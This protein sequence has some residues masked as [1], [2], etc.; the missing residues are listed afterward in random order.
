MQGYGLFSFLG[1]FFFGGGLFLSEQVNLTLK[2]MAFQII[3][4]LYCVQLKYI[5]FFSI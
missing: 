3:W 4:N 2:R 5:K 1:I